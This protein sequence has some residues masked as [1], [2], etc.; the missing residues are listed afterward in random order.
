MWAGFEDVGPDEVEKVDEGVF[1][2]E[3]LNTKGK[4]LDCRCCCLSMN[5][6]AISECVL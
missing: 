2:A 5:E 3:A 6:I 1:A 4:V